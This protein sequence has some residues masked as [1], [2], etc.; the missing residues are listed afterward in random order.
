MSEEW[1][2]S[3]IEAGLS[4]AELEAIAREA[5]GKKKEK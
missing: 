5:A 1:R 4:P 3:I 2:Q